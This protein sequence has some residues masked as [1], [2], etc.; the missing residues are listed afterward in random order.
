[1]PSVKICSFSGYYPHHYALPHNIQ[2]PFFSAFHDIG[3]YLCRFLSDSLM[4]EFWNAETC[5][6]ILSTNTLN[7][8]CNCWSAT[9]YFYILFIWFSPS[10][11]LWKYSKYIL[12][13]YR[14][15][16]HRVA[17]FYFEALCGKLS[18]YPRNTHIV[19]R[20]ICHT[21]FTSSTVCHEIM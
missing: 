3:H 15:G 6:S 14:A 10:Q 13:S 17:H 20:S 9:H 12:G 21:A 11:C 4:M 1:M 8:C 7:E 5:R 16:S 2:L 19:S 18:K